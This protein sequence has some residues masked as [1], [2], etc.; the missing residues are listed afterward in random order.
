MKRIEQIIKDCDSIWFEA[1]CIMRHLVSSCVW[2]PWSIPPRRERQEVL[3]R[4]RERRA[5]ER[6]EEERRRKEEE[7][8][9]EA[10]QLIAFPSSGHGLTMV[11]MD[12]V[13]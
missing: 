9:E 10:A 5:Q 6:L 7:E 1:D 13:V 8:K 4:A 11:D 12:Q 2:S 3:M